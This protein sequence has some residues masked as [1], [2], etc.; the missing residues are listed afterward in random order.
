VV[1][2]DEGRP[3]P[4]ML[5]A[6]RKPDASVPANPFRD[7][8][9]NAWSDEHGRFRLVGLEP[10]DWYLT[11]QPWGNGAS[12][13]AISVEEVRVRAPAVGIRITAA[14]P[15]SAVLRLLLPDGRPYVGSVAVYDHQVE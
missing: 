13:K 2:L 4:E 3:L 8:R 10:G 12:P 1:V 6:A 5:V 11:A 9:G 15:G 7:L 14:R